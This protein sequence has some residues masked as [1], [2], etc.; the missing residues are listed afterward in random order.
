[1][2]FLFWFGLFVLLKSQDALT[3]H[4]KALIQYQTL[5]DCCLFGT[6]PP[7]ALYT[8]RLLTGFPDYKMKDIHNKLVLLMTKPF[9]QN[10]SCSR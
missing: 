9:P 6:P 5:G 3:A 2:V 10:F 4:T 8:D 1:M 7:Q